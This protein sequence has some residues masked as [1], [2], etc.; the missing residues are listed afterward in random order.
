[1]EIVDQKISHKCLITKMTT[2]YTCPLEATCGYQIELIKLQKITT[3]LTLNLSNLNLLKL[4]LWSRISSC[5][6]LTQPGFWI[7]LYFDLYI[8]TDNSLPEHVLKVLTL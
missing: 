6:D 1:M 3:T 8:I 2:D 5:R 4:Y 7:C